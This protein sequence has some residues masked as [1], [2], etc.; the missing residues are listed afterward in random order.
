MPTTPALTPDTPYIKGRSR[1]HDLGLIGVGGMGEVRRVRDRRL[2]RVLV[3][4]TLYLPALNRPSLVARF[5][6]EAQVTTQL[7]HPGIVPIRNLGT[8]PDGR[9]WFTM[10][11]VAGQTFRELWQCTVPLSDGHGPLLGGLLQGEPD[12]SH[13]GVLAWEGTLG[14][15]D[16]PERSVDGLDC[17]GC[18]DLVV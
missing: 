16:L 17:V 5:L 10:K 12:D 4:Q 15:E 3:L 11:E 2:G 18:V 9:L 7:Q 14:L 6:E 1:Y 8:R 13:G